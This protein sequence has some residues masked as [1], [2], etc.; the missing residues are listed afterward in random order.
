MAIWKP[1]LSNKGEDLNMGRIYRKPKH[2]R[3]K[4]LVIGDPLPTETENIWRRP[5]R[6]Q[7]FANERWLN[8]TNAEEELE[9]ILTTLKN[10]VLRGKFVREWVCGKWI[11]D[12]FF[13]D[14]RLGIEVDGGYHSSPSQKKKDI[15][16]EADCQS[17]E[18]TLL[19]LTNEDV[20]G[21][22]DAL[23]TKLR[24]SYRRANRHMQ[25]FLAEFEANKKTRP[26]NDRTRKM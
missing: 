20:F 6:T 12:F 15:Q 25:V 10:G 3:G 19:R 8:P 18:I 13:P 22:R 11:L 16:K 2:W 14:N 1:A 24:D 23:L 21:N 4:T 9:R 17:V 7:G 5:R 26:R